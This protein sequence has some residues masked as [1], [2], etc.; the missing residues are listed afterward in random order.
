M[1]CPDCDGTGYITVEHD[2]APPEAAPCYG[3]GGTGHAH[4]CD[5]PVGAG[6]EI[7]NGGEPSDQPTTG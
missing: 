5:G 1:R 4:C 3:C 6:D 7:T 2:E